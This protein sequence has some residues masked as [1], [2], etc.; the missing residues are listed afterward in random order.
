M[1]FFNVYSVLKTKQPKEQ[2]QRD[3]C[4]STL[5]ALRLEDSEWQKR[6]HVI[7]RGLIRG[8]CYS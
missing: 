3:L 1:I 4:Y 6:F 7:W 5:V 8:G 2:N